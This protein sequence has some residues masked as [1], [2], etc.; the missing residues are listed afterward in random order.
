MPH[1]IDVQNNRPIKQRARE[2]APKV[3]ASVHEE[4]DNLLKADIIE[5]CISP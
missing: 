5:H 3:L 2:K 4:I 1:V